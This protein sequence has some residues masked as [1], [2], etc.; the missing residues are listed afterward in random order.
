MAE[1]VVFQ[2]LNCLVC[3]IEDFIERCRKGRCDSFSKSICIFRDGVFVDTKQCLYARII[4]DDD[5]KI[6]GY[7]SIAFVIWGII[8]R[9]AFYLKHSF[10]E[11][12]FC[13]RIQVES[14][15]LGP[16]D[17]ASLRNVGPV[18]EV[19]S[20]KGNQQSRCLPPFTW[21]RKQLQFPKRYGF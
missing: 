11:T 4:H 2:L 17:R 5:A 15:Q 12:G 10:S 6:L 9:T 1:S 16:T 18:I 20:F 3:G 8:R 13:L 7:K 19:T 21:G 14:V